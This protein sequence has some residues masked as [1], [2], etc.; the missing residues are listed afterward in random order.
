LATVAAASGGE[1]G[2]ELDHE[3]K[4]VWVKIVKMSEYREQQSQQPVQKGA[5]P[6]IAQLFPVTYNMRRICRFTQEIICKFFYASPSPGRF[7]EFR[8]PRASEAAIARGK[9]QRQEN[10]VRSSWLRSE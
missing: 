10:P 7:P 1:S 5:Q 6:A 4:A 3:S 9:K 2:F 8:F